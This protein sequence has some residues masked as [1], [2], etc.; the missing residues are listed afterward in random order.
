MFFKHNA[1]VHLGNAIMKLD[2]EKADEPEIKLQASI[3]SQQKQEN[4]RKKFNFCFTDYARV[5]DWVDHHKLFSSGQ[6]VSCV[7]LFPTHGQQHTRTPWQHQLLE[8][9]TESVIPSNHLILCH[10]LFL[11]PSNFFSIRVFSNESVLHIRWPNYWSFS[12]NIRPSKEYSTLISFRMD[13]LSL[14]AVQGTLKRLLK[15]QTSRGSIFNAQLSLCSNSNIHTW[16]LV[17]T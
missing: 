11:P 1:T 16:L 12:F 9:S 13:W 15:H 10:P 6:L 14:L 8:L 3:G 4:S 2:L 7:W 5:F 17:K